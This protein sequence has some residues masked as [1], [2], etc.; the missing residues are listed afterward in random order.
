M[1]P[2]LHQISAE[3]K[4]IFFFFDANLV[5]NKKNG[6]GTTPSIDAN[7]D[8]FSKQHQHKS[9]KK[10]HNKNINTH[11]ILYNKGHSTYFNKTWFLQQ[12]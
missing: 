1:V 4:K 6:A 10:H 2:Y 11:E 5:H 7:W 9:I 3:V 12:N 8:E